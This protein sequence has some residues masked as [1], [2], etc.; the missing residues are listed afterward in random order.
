MSFRLWTIFYVFA[1]LAAAM[2]TFGLWGLLATIVV[3]GYWLNARNRGDNYAVGFV[4]LFVATCVGLWALIVPDRLAA[5]VAEQR[6]VCRRRLM[7]IAL[8]IINY[9]EYANRAAPPT[10]VP[11]VNPRPVH[12]WRVLIT[13]YCIGMPTFLEQYKLDEPWDGRN[14][15][16]LAN[17][18]PPEYQCSNNTHH[19]LAGS[20]ETSF[21][22]VVGPNAAIPDGAK[23]QSSR[24]G[25]LRPS[26]EIHAPLMTTIGDGASKTIMLIEA[27]DR[28]INWMEPRDMT[29]DEA[30]ELLTTKPHSGH[31]DVADGFFSRTFYDTPFHTVVFCDG[32]AETLG[33]MNNPAV[34][35]ALLTA[36]GGETLPQDMNSLYGEQQIVPI[37]DNHQVGPCL[38]V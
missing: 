19:H 17:E 8:G 1:L 15:L 20:T 30:V 33:Q 6:S 11:N 9:D 27:N 22:A 4:V 35:R 5:Q 14:N 12:S 28:H 2:A 36:N 34:A 32:H 25:R 24:D 18:M 37:K 7:G 26:F 29:I 16:K 3:L 13:P 31:I 38:G 23:P 10:T 21:F